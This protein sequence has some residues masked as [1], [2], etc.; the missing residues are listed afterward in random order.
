ME[1]SSCTLDRHDS[2]LVVLEARP[3]RRERHLQAAADH[4]RHVVLVRHDV[5]RGEGRGF[6]GALEE[7]LL[8]AAVAVEVD[9]DA[10]VMT[11][12]SPQP[13]LVMTTDD[14]NARRE[15]FDRRRLAVVPR[16]RDGLRP[17]DRRE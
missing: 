8:R 4:D 7:M 10:A 6:D 9:D 15:E 13:V 16:E 11:A 17:I 12:R 3:Q 5:W 14:G 2:S 1:R